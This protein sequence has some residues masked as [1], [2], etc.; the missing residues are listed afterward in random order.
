M[1]YCEDSNI[2]KSYIVQNVESSDIFS[3][4]TEIYLTNIIPCTGDTININSNLNVTGD[5]SG[6]TFYGDGSQLSGIITTDNYVTGGVYTASTKSLYFTGTT[7]FTPFSIDVSALLDDTN[8]YVTGG[9]YN[10]STDTISLFRNDN[11]TIDITGVTD[12]FTTGGT[13]DNNTSLIT[14]VKNDNTSY[15]ID[16]SSIDV[17]DT[18]V[19]GSTLNGD[20]LTIRRNDGVDIVVTG[21]SQT[22]TGNTSGTCIGDIYVSNIHSCSPLHINPNDEGKVFFGSTSAV[23]IDLSN[24]SISIG[25]EDVSDNTTLQ[26]WTSGSTQRAIR[27]RDKVTNSQFNFW[28]TTAATGENILKLD[29]DTSGSTVATFYAT[30]I[31]KSNFDGDGSR[32]YNIPITGVTNLQNELDSKTD[33]TLFNSH[34]GD[35]NNPHQTSFSNL[36]ST[37]HT[38]SIGDV[39][40]L[41][42]ELDSKLDT[43]TFNTYSGNVETELNTKISGATNLS[44][45]GVFAQKNGL[46]LEFKGLTSTG[47]TV[48]ISSNSNSVNLEVTFPTDQDKF[49][50]GGTY[51]TGTQ[52]INFVGNSPETTFDVDLS[53]IISVD[54]YV[55][56]FT[57]NPSTYDL[58]IK[59]NEGQPDLVSNLAVLASDVYV[60]SGVY[61]PSTGIVTYTNS[62]GGT[63]QVSGF[64]TGMTDSYTTAANLNGETIEFDNNIQGSNLYNVSLSPVLSG[65]TDLTLFNSHT[66]NTNNPHQTSFSNLTS[67][68]HT[69][70]ISEIINLQTELDSKTNNTDFVSHT[71][72]T[73]IHFTKSSINLSDLGNTAHT[74]TLSEITDFNSYSGSVQTQI[75]GK[76]DLTLFNSHTGD[77]NNPHQTSFSNLTSTAHTH[78]I[79]DVTNLQSELDSKLNISDFNVYSG[80]VQTQ[81]DSKIEN[82]INS[83][84]ANEVFSGKS[85]TDLYFR[86]ISGGS[87]T[88]ISTIDDIIKVDVSV[89]VDTNTFVTGGTYSSGTLTL[90]RNDNNS[91][92]VTGFTSGGGDNFYV[93]GFTYDDA[94]TLTISRNGGL[95]DLTSTINTMTGLTIDG[96]LVVDTISATTINGSV[97][98]LTLNDLDDV[99]T[100]IPASPD[101]TYQG[102]LLYFDVTSNQWV[103]GAE[104]GNLGEVTIWG[105][106]G[107]AGTIDK[108][109]PV[110]ITGFDDDIHEVELAN[111]T[112]ASTMPV[113]GFTAED[114]DNAGVYPIITFGKI[115]GLDTTSGS[116]TLNPFGETWEVNDVL[117]MAKSDGGLTKNRPSG[118]NT[119]IQRVAKVLKV[120]TTDG[121]LFI[122]NTARTAGLPNLTTDY[123]WL[124][125]GNDT[126]QEVIRTDVGITTTGF[127]Y[128]DNN[129]FTIT[130]DNGGSLSSTFN[131]V[132]GLTVNGNI[133]MDN[134]ST[135]QIFSTSLIDI[136]SIQYAPSGTSVQLRWDGSGDSTVLSV[137][138]NDF[139][140]ISSTKSAYGGIVYGD[141]Y[142][143][144]YDVRSLIDLG[145]FNSNDRYVTGFTYND[146]NTFTLTRSSGLSDLTSTINTMSGLTINGN[147]DVNG[148]TE[149][150][151]T[152]N[153]GTLGTGTSV[154]NLGLD[155]NGN[156][157]SGNTNTGIYGGDGTIPLNT[158]A[159]VN[160]DLTFQGLDEDTRI[161]LKDGN[162]GGEVHLFSDGSAGQ[163]A[164][165][166]Y[167]PGGVT[168]TSKIQNAGGDTRFISNSRDLLFTTN[169]GV[170]TEG[171]FIEAGTGNMGIGTTTP[172]VELHVKGN[173][174]ILRLETTSLTNNNYIEFWDPTERKGFLGY[175]S[176]F[177][178]DAL[179]IRNEEDDA[180]IIISTTDSGGTS[181]TAIDID[182][183]QNVELPNGNLDVNGTLTIGTLG[184]GTSVTNLGIDTSGNVVS[185]T[186][187]GSGEVNTASNLG[188][189]TGLFAQKNGVDL[190]FK[191]LTSTGGTV[192]I[193]NNST[194]VNIESAGGGTGVSDANKIFS[195]FMNVT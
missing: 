153:I 91:V 89:P 64:T 5:I 28:T 14:F 144:N 129:T 17:N 133:E 88:T 74:H 130:D 77:T 92:V 146:N 85:G 3:A 152:L 83:G 27:M 185:G 194:T 178:T 170:T 20:S 42:T 12:T 171:F 161:I 70:S 147:L 115:T 8:N 192:T 112:T 169:T 66:G 110:Y 143:A 48:N 59:Q 105:K 179:F 69:H 139:T 54:T 151:G 10:P 22:F 21:F 52:E 132:S 116:T 41:Q 101:N 75:G 4:C 190:E 50:S 26:V 29:E 2:N 37:A 189:G 124:G 114:F 107:S 136:S 181:R 140:S 84:G 61:N 156:V 25:G 121:Q 168:L 157:V 40:N 46:N 186:T 102:E 31:I 187:G 162:N 104:Y 191:S 56:G 90:D 160:G 76:T 81:L 67:T 72:D 165:E 53:S 154:N 119:Q 138:K 195:W 175:V 73:T 63:F 125:N 109:L 30:G 150:S 134:S 158:T 43:T 95:S 19:T 123:L 159:S 145:Y 79:S 65:K 174:S 38:H 68:A 167:N 142:S 113:I 111:A 34:T 172:S 98:G 32:L 9:T 127:T 44:S 176:T 193:T 71:G 108:G 117:Y 60:V 57:F 45:E 58:T 36:T 163:S 131:Q 55:T 49:V 23:T 180:D 137:S 78:T 16:L 126:P 148:N 155:I 188:G 11:V 35:T 51:N 33:L 118:T 141:D 122:F 39:I 82:G 99:T 7:G 6:T 128:N 97:T 24:P 149:I 13:Y 182:G 166:F 96:T 86:T 183:N 184:T 177:N 15:T 18:F 103:S 164:L 47:G 100:N 106:K 80:N 93:T 120:G 87:N 1:S 62:S 173:S 135:R 94:N